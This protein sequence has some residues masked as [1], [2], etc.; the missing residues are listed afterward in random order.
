MRVVIPKTGTLHDIAIQVGATSGNISVAVYSAA[1]TRTRLYTTGAIACPAANGWRIAGDPNLSVVAGEQYDF[2]LSVDNS[3]ATFGISPV[4]PDTTIKTLPT[5]FLSEVTGTPI[6]FWQGD[7]LHPL[8]AT[9]AEASIA[10]ATL[11]VIH[12]IA[13][14]T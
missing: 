6:L 10:V 1:L 8:P 9:L 13:R 7:S 4:V 5:G 2:A 3:S 11:A 12:I 14:I